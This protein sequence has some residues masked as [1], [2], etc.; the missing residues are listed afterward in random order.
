M[1]L[2]EE[3]T[4][5][6]EGKSYVVEVQKSGEELFANENLEFA[7]HKFET[8]FMED[9]GYEK[10]D[11]SASANDGSI[12]WNSVSKNKGGDSLAWEGSEIDGKIHGTITKVSGKDLGVTWT[13]KS[14][15]RE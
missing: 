9:N 2:A 5:A 8:T 10:A 7:N 14:A 11:Y 4:N 15:P 6:L 1:V 13:F 12:K 3:G